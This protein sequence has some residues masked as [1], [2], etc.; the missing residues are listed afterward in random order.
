MIEQ[1]ARRAVGRVHGA[2]EAPRVRQQLA[3][4]RGAQL[5]EEGAAVDRAEVRDEAPIIQA[6][7]YDREPGRLLQVQ[8]RVRHE[9]AC[10]Q[11]VVEL[12][13]YVGVGRTLLHRS[14]E[15]LGIVEIG[16]W[17]RHGRLGALRGAHVALDEAPQGEKVAVKVLFH[18]HPEQVAWQ[19]DFLVDERVR[20][21]LVDP[22]GPEGVHLLEHEQEQLPLG[23]ELVSGQVDEHVPREE[24]LAQLHVR[25]PRRCAHHRA[26]ARAEE[27]DA[28]LACVQLLVECRVLAQRGDQ[29]V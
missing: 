24:E 1:S 22:A 18:E 28:L 25:E 11:E 20:V 4:S 19:Q 29:T 23:R 9:V 3:H 27:A 2:E 10:A 21:V 13:A 8:P 5:R 12:P 14:S 15:P 26:E 17:W 7:G 16:R 6:L